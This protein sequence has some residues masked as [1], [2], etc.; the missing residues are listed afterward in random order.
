MGTIEDAQQTIADGLLKILRTSFESRASGT[1]NCQFPIFLS[2]AF[3]AFCILRCDGHS[4][5]ARTHLLWAQLH[6]YP[7]FRSVV[8]S[9]PMNLEFKTGK[10]DEYHCNNQKQTTYGQA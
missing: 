1:E 3:V 6:I 7:G 9:N 2:P 4:P 8:D 5:P 10:S